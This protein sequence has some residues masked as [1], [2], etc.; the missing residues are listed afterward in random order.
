[1]KRGRRGQGKKAEETQGKG[2]RRN[3]RR[4]QFAI[5]A[6]QW[7]GEAPG[8]HYNEHRQRGTNG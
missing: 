5:A 3:K 4:Q 1:M 2:Q 6:G 7:E 8:K